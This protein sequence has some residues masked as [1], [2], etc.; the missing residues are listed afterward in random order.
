MRIINAH[1]SPNHDGRGH[2][3]V[4]MLVIHYTDMLTCDA[5]RARLCDAAAQVSAHYLISETGDIFALVD[6][7]QRAWHAGVS[8][9]R[10]ASNIN[11][12][13]VGIELANP[14]HSNGYVPFPAA[15][16]EALA[17]LCQGILARHPIPPRNVQGHSDIAFLRKL[18]PGELFD[19]RWMAA[20]GIGLFPEHTVPISG[21]E[22][23]RGDKGEVVMRLQQA[24]A[25]W[26]YGLKTDGEYG[27]KTESCVT[28][29]QR[30]FLPQAISGRWCNASAG[31]LAALHADI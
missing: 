11:A 3:L 30:H 26:G 14:G 17:A 9:W 2:Q 27:E 4:D 15:Q 16:M 20:R 23:E 25:N 1:R 5:A 13:S 28:A 12:R 24:L 18:D 6:E 29:F 19:W 31:I 22:L 7:D 10:G 21:H 8:A